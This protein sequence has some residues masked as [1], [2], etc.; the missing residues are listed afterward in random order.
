LLLAGGDFFVKKSDRF[1]LIHKILGGTDVPVTAG[2]LAARC[3]VTVRTIYRDISDLRAAGHPIAGDT[4]PGGGLGIESRA[5]SFK[6]N[7]TPRPASAF[8]RYVGRS[9]LIDRLHA[10][11][12][13][14]LTGDFQAVLLSGEPGSGKTRS[15]SEAATLAQQL[16]FENY[17]GLSYDGVG[18]PLLWPWIQILRQIAVDVPSESNHMTQAIST[19][20]IAAGP[21]TVMREFFNISLPFEV[22]FRL[23]RSRTHW[24]CV[25]DVF[26]RVSCEQ[27][28]RRPLLPLMV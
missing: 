26:T 22:Q 15:A 21:V 6:P 18:A 2:F 7:P 25:R 4:V 28:P 11:L 23:G 24:I 10:T 20:P 14:A 12:A 17:W 13:R 3:G 19:N 9:I 8:T 16:G 5:T 27:H 1:A